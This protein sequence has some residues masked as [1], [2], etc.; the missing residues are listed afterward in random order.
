MSDVQK[1]FN[2]YDFVPRDGRDTLMVYTKESGYQHLIGLTDRKIQPKGK[3]QSCFVDSMLRPSIQA[4]TCTGLSGTGKT[5]MAI[6]SAFEL[7]QS[8]TNPIE[9]IVLCKPFYRVGNSDAVGTLPGE[10]ADKI[11]PY[12]EHFKPLIKKMGYDDAYAGVMI[13]RGVI[14]FEPIEFMRGKT[15]EN[16]FIVVD[17]AQSLT[18]TEIYTILSRT[19]QGSKIVFLGD[20]N[21][22]DSGVLQR[23][24]GLKLLHD[25]EEFQRSSLT[26]VH[27]LTRCHRSPIAELSNN[28]HLEILRA[29]KRQSATGKN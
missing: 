23:D 11:G 4:V 18:W 10:V 28:I 27:H 7:L 6:A 3:E 16:A 17:E 21:Q 14:R 22:I 26:A 5:L 8:Q 29:N 20:L 1:R 15:Y 19:G 24:S 25:S 13:K 2:T 9:Q 12:I